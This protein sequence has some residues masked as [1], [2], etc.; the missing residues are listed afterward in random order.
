[1]RDERNG[2][3][4]RGKQ[5]NVRIERRKEGSQERNEGEEKT[6]TIIII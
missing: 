1:M 4:T 2:K 5:G 3:G 6:M